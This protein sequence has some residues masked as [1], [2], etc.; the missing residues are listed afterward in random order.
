MEID[1]DRVVECARAYV[2]CILTKQVTTTLLKDK[3]RLFLQLR[4]ALNPP[5]PR[6]SKEECIGWLERLGSKEDKG[7]TLKLEDCVQLVLLTTAEYLKEPCLKLVKNT[8]VKPEYKVVMV[9]FRHGGVCCF[10][11]QQSLRWH[12][13]SSDDESADNDVIEYIILE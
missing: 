13:A 9:R 4:D 2:E 10:H 12:F 1:K 5:P 6:P 8:G 11:S 7:K 3:E